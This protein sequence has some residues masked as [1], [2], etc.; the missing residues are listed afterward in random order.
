LPGNI[1]AENIT[2]A[3]QETDYDITSVKQMIAKRSTPEAEVTHT[4][5]PLFLFT[6]ARY[7]NP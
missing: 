7:K 3:L 6:L 4:S 1:S 5:L 2:V